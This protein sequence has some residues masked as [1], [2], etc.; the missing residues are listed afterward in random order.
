MGAPS[1]CADAGVRLVDLKTCREE[2]DALRD[3]KGPVSGGEHQSL[4]SLDETSSG[5]VLAV[6]D[7]ARRF[8]EHTCSSGHDNPIPAGRTAPAGHLEH[9][10]DHSRPIKGQEV[11][12]GGT[13]WINL[14]PWS[15][16]D[17]HGAL[18]VLLDDLSLK[19]RS[20]GVTTAKYDI[21]IFDIAQAFI[22]LSYWLAYNAV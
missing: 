19:I 2:L 22:V 11:R 13:V 14:V 1:G 16:G 4:I 9:A 7:A 3:R 8:D 20:G 5:A 12:S 21:A 10:P 6:L 18:P 17:H 15:P